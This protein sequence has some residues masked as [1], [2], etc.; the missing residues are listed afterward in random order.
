MYG[1]GYTWLAAIMVE[2]WWDKCAI[3]KR[4]YCI[5]KKMYCILD[6]S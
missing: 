1:I 2:L 3:V 4:R 6:I 5:V